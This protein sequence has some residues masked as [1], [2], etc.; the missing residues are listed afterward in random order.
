V[1][2]PV[3]FIFKRQIPGN[4]F[5]AFFSFEIFLN[6][7]TFMSDARRQELPLVTNADD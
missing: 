1:R 3:Y 4:A 6:V 5:A 7:A 2:L